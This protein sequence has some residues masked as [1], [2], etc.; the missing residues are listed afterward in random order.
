MGRS[1]YIAGNFDREDH[2]GFAAGLLKD[3]DAARNWLTL[4]WSSGAA[5]GNLCELQTMK[6][7]CTAERTSTSSSASLAE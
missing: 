2:G 1:D 4:P 7:S 6:G 3:Y 5:E